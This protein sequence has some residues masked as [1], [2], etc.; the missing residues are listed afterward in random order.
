MC[1][2]VVWCTTEEEGATWRKLAGLKS[3]IP[4]RRVIKINFIC[5]HDFF[6]KKRSFTS[7]EPGYIEQAGLLGCYQKEREV[8]KNINFKL[9]NFCKCVLC[10]DDI[11]H[12]PALYFLPSSLLSVPF[13]LVLSL[14]QSRHTLTLLWINKVCGSQ[15]REQNIC[16][17]ILIS[18]SHFSLNPTE[19]KILQ[20]S[21]MYYLESIQKFCSWGWRDG[22][23]GKNPGSASV[24]AW[25]GTHSFHK[26]SQGWLHM[27]ALEVGARQIPRA[28]GPV[29]LWWA[30]GSARD[31]VCRQ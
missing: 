23:M 8:L 4:T 14:L 31:P 1:V 26:N 27:P 3:L 6:S 30:S 22:S 21:Q 11:T 7:C 5:I 24:R 19:G 28:H 20:V 2:C 17:R 18:I 9:K 15:M 16:L 25:I 13:S 12:I 10:V 29:S